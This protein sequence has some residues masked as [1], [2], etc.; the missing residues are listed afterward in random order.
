MTPRKQLP[1]AAKRL[2]VFFVFLLLCGGVALAR[3]TYYQWFHVEALPLRVEAPITR[4]GRKI[5]PFS[6]IPGGVLDPQELA[7]SMQRDPVAREHYQDVNPQF[8]WTT[9]ADQPML[10]YVSYRKGNAVYWTEHEVK[11]AAGERLLTDGVH[12]I[13]GRCGNRISFKRPTPLARGFGPPEG[14]PP[15][16]AFE[17]PLPDMIPPSISEPLPPTAMISKS[18]N[19]LKVP[20]NSPLWCCADRHSTSSTPEPGTLVLL[21]AGLLASIG[22]FRRPRQ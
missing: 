10:A 5:Y 9:S 12:L 15:Q 6:V 13:R 21:G 16:I 3:W 1:L 4:A 22:C 14:P 19:P 7:T 17:T 20:G 18:Q 2:I 8:L 11:I